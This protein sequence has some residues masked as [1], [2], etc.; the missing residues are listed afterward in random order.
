MNINK[1]VVISKYSIHA[2]LAKGGM[3]ELY[4][5]VDTKTNRKVVLKL[6]RTDLNNPVF[7]DAIRYEGQLLSNL[8]HPGIVQVLPISYVGKI[9]EPLYFERAIGIQGQPW[10]YVMEPLMGNSLAELLGKKKPL[11]VNVAAAI[12]IN[13]VNTLAYLHHR[14]PSIAHLDIKPENIMFRHPLTRTS[15]LEPVLIDFGVAVMKGGRSGGGTLPTMPPDYLDFI[16]HRLPPETKV[17]LNVVDI[18]ALGVVM[19]RMVTGEYPFS[20]WGNN[21]LTT[22]IRKGVYRA[23]SE[24][25]KKISQDLDDLIY[26]W[27]NREPTRRPSLK[28]LRDE[29]ARFSNGVGP[30]ELTEELV[31]G[32]EKRNGGLRSKM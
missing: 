18:Y 5:A 31:A 14:E 9:Q 8:K 15:P 4:E 10:F 24:L 20:G 21:G 19:Y 22:S 3:A 16:E 29:L 1:G 11:P 6:G 17:D 27:M 25:N 30:F 23:P 2:A 26:R 7:S 32:D 12:A 13:L 28:Q